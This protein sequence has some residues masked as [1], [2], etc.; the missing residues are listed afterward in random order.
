MVPG[1]ILLATTIVA[2]FLTWNALRGPHNDRHPL[3]RPPWVF[4]L[5]TAE[6][7]PIHL[8][9]LAM[10][11]GLAWLTGGLRSA[12]GRVALVLLVPVALLYVVLLVRAFEARSTMRRL[13]KTSDIDPGPVR[14]QVKDIVSGWPFAVPPGVERIEDI[15]YAPGGQLDVYRSR[16]HSGQAPALLQIHGGSWSA[17][18]RRQQ[19]RP[20]MHELARRGW[21]CVAVSYPLAPEVSFPDQLIV[22]KQALAWMR[23]HG[24]ELG[25]D[26]DRIA[27]TGGSAGAHL[28]TLL[29]LTANRAVY[30]PGFST[31][32]TSVQAAVAMYGIFDLLNRQ[33]TR[34]DF[35]VI[36]THLMQSQPSED[37]D[38]Y[39]AAS[40]LDQVRPD[41][42]PF[43]VVHGAGD[44]LVAPAESAL[45]VRALRAVSSQ[46]VLHAVIPGATHAFDAI[47]SLRTQFVV[48]GVAGFLEA[49]MAGTLERDRV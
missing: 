32:D 41:A 20:L 4:V 8:A 5:F 37:E 34:D 27:V 35:D 25:V 14:L 30:Q 12:Q 45:F 38:R 9:G 46:P 10:V 47:P 44:S 13:L 29:A 18:N 15:V 33:R 24:T 16:G 49:A 22:L 43:L 39:R 3:R 42:P 17:G 26:P 21:V 11:T 40:P 31:V 28:A 7:V 48:N 19:G 1:S 23:T 6:L 2:L 36:H